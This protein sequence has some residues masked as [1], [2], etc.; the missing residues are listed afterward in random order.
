M[1]VRE[2]AVAGRFYAADPD[3]LRREVQ[4]HLAGVTLAL[5]D[6]PP[7]V[8]VPHA[9][10]MYSGP[11]AAT[12]YAQLHTAQRVVVAGP[13]HY[14]PVAGLVAPRAQAWR[15]PLGLVEIDE[16]GIGDAG[17]P[18][19]DY[20]HAPEHSLEVQLPFL[21]EQLAPGWRLLPILV[22][23]AGPGEV[24]DAL[25]PLLADPGT[26]VVLSTDLSHYHRYETAVGQDRATAQR[27]VSGD[28]QGI[29]DDDACGA[30]PLRGLLLAAQRMG[31]A[32][33]QLDLRNSGDTAGPHDRV[34]GYGAFAVGP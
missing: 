1:A 27:I 17:L 4:D 11:V 15:T 33:V 25:E 23:R 31:G 20:P 2:P 16:G 5:P 10:H 3:E 28:W 32:I 19:D 18:R 29:A 26:V 30:Y 9:G 8:I 6:Q 22:G 21:Q 24:A 13:A 7:A 12:A 14:V 34:V